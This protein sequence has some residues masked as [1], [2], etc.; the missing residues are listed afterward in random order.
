MSGR[1]TEVLFRA[2]RYLER[3]GVGAPRATAEVLLADLLGTDRAGLYTRADALTPAQAREFGRALCR[4]CEGV[5]LQHLT[6]EQ[7]FRTIV[8][9]VRPGVF[10]PRPET[11]VVVEAALDAIADVTEPVVVDV[12][13]GTGAIALAVAAER[14]DAR[15]L[16]IDASSAAVDLARANAVALGLPVEVLEGDLLAPLPAALLG[17]V[18]LVVSN[19]PYVRAEEM[20]ALPRDVLADPRTALVGDLALTERLAR[21]AREALRPGGTLVLEIGETQAEE[22][23]SVLTG[24]D[25]IR[26]V[27]DLT[28]R[29]R[30][31]VAS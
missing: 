6:G 30:V 1:P 21:G 8:L 27:Q 7:A 18:D 23:R 29:D 22:V 19:P 31:V 28:G 5:P 9:A 2:E 20:A 12:G 3:H 15:V 24:F 16:A 17:R 14:P 11:E 13:T 4:R 10:I 26:V 25:A